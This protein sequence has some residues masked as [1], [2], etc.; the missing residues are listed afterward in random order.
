MALP[1]I[2]LVTHVAFAAAAWLVGLGVEKLGASPVA[3]TRVW[4]AAPWPPPLS[5][6]EYGWSIS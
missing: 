1:L 3:R 6:R 2:L 5:R 4:A